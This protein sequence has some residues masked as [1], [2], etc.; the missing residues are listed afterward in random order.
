MLSEKIRAREE[1]EMK[2]RGNIQLIDWKWNCEQR[3]RRRMMVTL[4]IGKTYRQ[5]YIFC[6]FLFLWNFQWLGEGT[7][8]IEFNESQINEIEINFCL[9]CPCMG[10]WVCKCLYKMFLC[11]HWSCPFTLFNGVQ[12]VSKWCAMYHVPDWLIFSSDSAMRKSIECKI[13]FTENT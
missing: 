3:R 4:N 2:E 6:S 9:L 13:L 7:Q 10:Y 5:T 1:K 11:E 12:A 8:R